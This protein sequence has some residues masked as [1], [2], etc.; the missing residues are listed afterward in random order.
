MYA[1]KNKVQL[2]GNLGAAPEIRSFENDRKLA[3]FSLA[4]SEVY[5][6]AKG[7]KMTETQWHNV[8]VWGKLADIA[9]LRVAVAKLGQIQKSQHA[10][11]MVERNNNDIAALA[12]IFAVV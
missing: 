2:I 4:T 1:L 12:Q 5:E 6:N 11:P 8:V 9:G 3:R 7:E 10:Q